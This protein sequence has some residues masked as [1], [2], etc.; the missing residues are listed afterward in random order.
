MYVLQISQGVGAVISSS[1]GSGG[2][3]GSLPPAPPPLPSLSG[4]PLPPPLPGQS[5]PG[6]PPLPP[7]LG[8][9]RPPGPGSSPFVCPVEQLPSFVKP[10]KKY[11]PEMQMKRANWTKVTSLLEY[12]TGSFCKTE[13]Y[14]TVHPVAPHCT[15]GDIS[16]L[17]GFSVTF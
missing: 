1:L 14:V 8:M 11:Q 13:H 6:A 10:K 2:P 4:P 7:P 17:W 9:M 3:P 16:F 15:N 5:V 12:F